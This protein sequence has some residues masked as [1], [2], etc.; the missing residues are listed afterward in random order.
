MP[1]PDIS[2]SFFL[3]LF[4]LPLGLPPLGFGMPLGLP[5]LLGDRTSKRLKRI[6]GFEGLGKLGKDGHGQRVILHGKEKEIKKTI[7]HLHNILSK[8]K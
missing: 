7:Q 2:S 6:E 4:K 8:T 3:L 5:L 1:L